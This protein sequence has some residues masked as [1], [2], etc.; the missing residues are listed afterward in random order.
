MKKTSATLGKTI[1][2][3]EYDKEGNLISYN[4]SKNFNYTIEY[5]YDSKNNWVKSITHY[6]TR[7]SITERV[8]EYY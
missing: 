7:I 2:N 6:P 4:D 1:K 8:I 3:W 5:T